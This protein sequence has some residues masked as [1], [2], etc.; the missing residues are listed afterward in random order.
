MSQAPVNFTRVKHI[1]SYMH[2]RDL[3]LHIFDLSFSVD[4]LSC[5]L[6]FFDLFT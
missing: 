2:V 1:S 4:L 6:T 5:S 3:V